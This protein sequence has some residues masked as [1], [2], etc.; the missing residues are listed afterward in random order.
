MNIITN[1][2]FCLLKRLK[3]NAASDLFF[4][5][6]L[7]TEMIKRNQLVSS[8]ATYSWAPNDAVV[9]CFTS[10]TTGRPKGVTISH[11]AFTTQSLAKI[12]IVGYGEDD[13]RLF[14]HN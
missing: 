9:I 6:V 14:N 1:V 7:T 13:V 4:F 12:A 10:G 8:L 3:D 5:S 2:C 11:L